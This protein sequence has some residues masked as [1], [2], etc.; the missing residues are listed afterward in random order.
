MAV[1]GSILSAVEFWA[2]RWRARGGLPRLG[3]EPRRVFEEPE[4]PFAERGP[5]YYA[6]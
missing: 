5:G 1:A 6:W 2:C 4:V 3:A